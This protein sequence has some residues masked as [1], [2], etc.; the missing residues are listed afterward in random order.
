MKP[1]EVVRPRSVRELSAAL[2]DAH[3]RRLAVVPWGG[4]T[5]MQVG[6]LPE[7]YDVALDMTGL[8]ES[9]QHEPGDLTLVVD[10]GMRV[11]DISVRLGKAGHRLPFDVPDPD[12]ATI[13]GSV[14]SNAAGVM[15][16]STGG[17]RD[18]VIGM[19]VVQPD[20]TAT[21]SGGRVV[22]NV[23]GY[24]LHRLHT[25]AFGTLGVITEIAF[26]LIPV[27]EVSKTVA[28]IFH[29]TERA[30]AA[31]STIFNGYVTPEAWS[32]F[33]GGGAADVAARYI[34]GAS[35]ARK[36][37]VMLA[38]VAGGPAAVDRQVSEVVR[39]VAD[40]GGLGT[41]VVDGAA[42]E[43]VWQ[44]AG[45]GRLAPTV[46]VRMSMKPGNIYRV[47]ADLES[48][49]ARWP[50]LRVWARADCG[51]GAV[52]VNWWAPDDAGARD[53][54]SASNSVAALRGGSAVIESCPTG[55]KRGLDVF[56]NPVPG[57]AIMR[58]L[59]DQFDPGRNLNPGRFAGG[60]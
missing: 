13:G 11:S 44:D 28:A 55:L 58:R 2:A 20:G 47:I 4:G 41:A 46:C 19:Q 6:N 48:V 51:Y 49:E 25:G 35:D 21:K 29:E 17:I 54:I 39:A 60:I 26:K 15:R 57:L 40:A 53:A 8:G 31:A 10:A 3:K 42:Q 23:Q 7:K 32:F 1:T 38:R 18:W 43:G 5:R 16:S 22:K 37:Y 33:T 50:K 56:G 14:A 34:P 27:P 30:A 9:F 12:R 59:K 52:T 36:T 45:T 24:D